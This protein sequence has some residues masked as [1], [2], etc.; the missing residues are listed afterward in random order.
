LIGKKFRILNDCKALVFLRDCR[1]LN[2]R[3]TRWIIFLQQFDFEIEHYIGKQYII[4]VALS[5]NPW[6]V[7]ALEKNE[8]ADDITIAVIDWSSSQ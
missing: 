6:D 3:L 5:R 4:A 8:L 7:G 1:L 2:G